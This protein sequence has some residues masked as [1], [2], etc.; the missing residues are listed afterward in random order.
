MTLNGTANVTF[1]LSNTPYL[2]FITHIC[3]VDKPVITSL[4]E[5][6]IIVPDERNAHFKRNREKIK[7]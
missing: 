1:D 2:V 6:C 5:I 7:I 3:S 4:Q